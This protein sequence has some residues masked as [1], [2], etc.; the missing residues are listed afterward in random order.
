MGTSDV[1]DAAY[2]DNLPTKKPA[3]KGSGTL[4]LA[5]LY[6]PAPTIT[7]TP[8]P[9]AV[10]RT[11][12]SR[13]L[14][15]VGQGP[16]PGAV[17]HQP[18]PFVQQNLGAAIARKD[19]QSAV[20]E[21]RKLI[22][23]ALVEAKGA[24]SGANDDALARMTTWFGTRPVSPAGNT[25]DWWKGVVT[26]L[27]VIESYLTGS[28]NLYYR[29]DNSVI[30]KPT[31]YPNKTGNLT[32]HDVSGY[33]E[34]YAGD[35]DSNIGLCSLFFAKQVGTG[36]SRMNLRGFDSVGGTLIHELSHNLCKTKDHE[37]LS[38]DDAYGTDDCRQLAIDLPRR[39]WYNAD[40]I[41]YFSEEVSYGRDTAT[42]V[43]IGTVQPSKA[44]R[45]LRLRQP[46]S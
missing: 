31:D 41:E 23:P 38:G 46:T 22:G 15:K 18:P 26:I 37:T 9:I 10:A 7:V 16:K 11:L 24:M 6:W 2:F 19:A 40:N 27:G 36:Q 35:Q 30:G 12:Q 43:T 25:R 14:Y 5:G 44:V 13:F 32:A 34:T 3:K 8:P 29:G 20:D 45:D 42:P 1:D 4:V 28:I 39:A 17:I 33:A 21:A